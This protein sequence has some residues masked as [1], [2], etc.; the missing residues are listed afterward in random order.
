MS[1]AAEANRQLQPCR[2]G[3]DW[4]ESDIGIN[5]RETGPDGR[6]V[7]GEDPSAPVDRSVGVIRVDDLEGRAIAML[8]SYGCHT[9]TMGPRS[10]VASPDFPG[11]ARE[12]VE[13]AFGG[14]QFGVT[15]LG[16]DG[17]ADAVLALWVDA[18]GEALF[19]V[20]E[21]L[22]DASIHE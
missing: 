6:D 11:P 16:P 22:H 15:A 19:A 17:D 8:F 7:L 14:F 5:R 1:V 13:H 9:V 2:I 3:A 18:H 20:G 10:M 21:H 12:L 4:G